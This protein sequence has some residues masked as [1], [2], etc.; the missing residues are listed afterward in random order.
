VDR[1][2]TWLNG[3][4]GW[5]LFVLFCLEALPLALMLSLT[6]NVA[7]SLF[8]GPL[9]TPSTI[10]GAAVMAVPGALALACL[11]LWLHPRAVRSA[12][13]RYM[14]PYPLLSWRAFAWLLLFSTSMFMSM[15]AQAQPIQWHRGHR[16]VFLISTITGVAS[17]AFL[18][19]HLW[20]IRRLRQRSGGDVVRASG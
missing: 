17:Y 3:Q 10:A 13:K 16:E 11:M 2:D 7:W 5:R 20:Y 8:S 6:L 18:G 9:P 14:S 12:R 15:R 4:H 1:L 19:W